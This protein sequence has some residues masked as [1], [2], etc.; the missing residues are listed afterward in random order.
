MRVKDLM[1][2]GNPTLLRPTAEMLALLLQLAVLEPPSQYSIVVTPSFEWGYEKFY[3][4][5]WQGNLEIREALIAASK[6]RIGRSHR[7]RSW[8]I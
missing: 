5:E 4:P 3:G 7:R 1:R 8:A 6:P 2:T